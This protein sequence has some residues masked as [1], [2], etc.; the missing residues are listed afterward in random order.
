MGYPTIHKEILNDSPYD[1]SILAIHDSHRITVRRATLGTHEPVRCVGPPILQAT[2]LH[3]QADPLDCSAKGD[4]HLLAPGA[5]TTIP[6]SHSR[7]TVSLFL[8]LRMGC[9]LL[10]R[11]VRAQ[12]VSAVSPSKARNGYR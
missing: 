9:R 1:I 11:G 7:T 10:I 4:R 2:H 6:L 5:K 3:P 8:F 12:P